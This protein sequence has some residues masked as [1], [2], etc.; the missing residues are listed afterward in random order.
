MNFGFEDKNFAIQSYRT[1]EFGRVNQS[2]EWVV[3]P[4]EDCG[5]SGKFSSII[6]NII[7]FHEK[8]LC[9]QNKAFKIFFSPFFLY[10]NT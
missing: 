4:C 3:C 2:H 10:R 9:I 7:K 5:I 1:R 6:K 8:D